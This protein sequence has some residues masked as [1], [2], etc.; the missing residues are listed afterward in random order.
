MFHSFPA[1]S[2]LPEIKSPEIKSPEKTAQAAAL[3]ER[4]AVYA[5]T[6]GLR[7]VPYIILS[8][9][10]MTET[11]A[12]YLSYVVACHNMPDQLLTCVPAAKAGPPAQQLSAYDSEP[13][14]HGIVYLPN[15]KMG[16][17]GLKVL[18]LSEMLRIGLLDDFTHQELPD[19]P[20]TLLQVSSTARRASEARSIPTVGAAPNRRRS[21]LVAV[22]GYHEGQETASNTKSDL[23]RARSRIQGNTLRDAG[24]KCNDLWRVALKMLSLSRSTC[25]LP[26]QKR[27]YTSTGHPEEV[28]PSAM[29]AGQILS[30]CKISR[31]QLDFPAL[32]TLSPKPLRP[33][34]TITAPLST[35]NPNHSFTPRF[36]HY[37]NG[38]LT[39]LTPIPTPPPSTATCPPTPPP[40]PP[41]DEDTYRSSLPAGFSPGI[42]RRIIASAVGADQIMSEAQQRSVLRWG[43]DRGTLNRERESLGLAEHAQIWRVLE[44]T[45]CLAHEVNA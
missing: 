26:R 42:W 12:L 7:S 44:G 8:D 4:Q 31:E 38:T 36:H 39:F 18:E 14:C 27:P 13:H 22:S 32:P 28:S 17:A 1:E 35:G 29:P 5:L 40:F 15:S 6:R 43:M 23:D 37:Q 2:S 30:R 11:C 45:G 21:V 25:L 20:G 24:P 34:R 41:Q 33:S 3:A 9:T 10:A 16:N 19:T